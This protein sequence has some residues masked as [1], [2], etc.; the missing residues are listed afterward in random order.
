MRIGRTVLDIENLS[1]EDLTEV[2]KE[3]K[4]LRTRKY[5]AEAL[6]QSLES[7]CAN[8]KENHQSICSKYT[9]EVF[10]PQDWVI[11]DDELDRVMVGEWDV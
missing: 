10:N 3:A 7:L 11:F 9:G 6:K 2:I 8:A 5:E 1:A 4:R